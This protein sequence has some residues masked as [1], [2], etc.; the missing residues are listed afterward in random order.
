MN[1]NANRR[2]RDVMRSHLGSAERQ[3]YE[4]AMR[5]TE[6]MSPIARAKYEQFVLFR[7]VA[8]VGRAR[9]KRQR[10]KS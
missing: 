6:T 3:A 9:A 1:N 2:S 7:L 4:Q 8:D 5:G 10:K